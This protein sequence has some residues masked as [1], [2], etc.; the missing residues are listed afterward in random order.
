MLTVHAGHGSGADFPARFTACF[1]QGVEDA[2]LP[3]DRRLR[4]AL[5]SYME[6]AS[7]I[8]D[9]YSPA[10]SVVADGLPLPRWGW[11]GLVTA[12]RKKALSR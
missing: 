7:R 8:V 4:T 5:R 10:G 6:W 12:S 9:S 3:K 2:G 11:S 1:M